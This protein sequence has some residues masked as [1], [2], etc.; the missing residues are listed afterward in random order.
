MEQDGTKSKEAV[1]HVEVRGYIM[2]ILFSS[3][4]EKRI[5]GNTNNMFTLNTPP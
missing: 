3:H 2:S 4:K 1:V 5:S